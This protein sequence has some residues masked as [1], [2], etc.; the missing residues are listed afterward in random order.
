MTI[1]DLERLASGQGWPPPHAGALAEVLLEN[2]A[3][4]DARLRDT[5]SFTLMDRLIEDGLLTVRQRIDLLQTA[6]DDDHLF[7]GIGESITDGVFRRSFSV[8]MVPMVL[9]PDLSAG[10]LPEDL[11]VWTLDR[12]L[13]YARAERDWRGYVADK[14]WAH[15]VAHTADALDI[16]GRH[17]KTPLAQ[18]SEVLSAIHYLA[19]LAY[20]LGY[21]EDDRLAFAAYRIIQSGR[22]SPDAIQ[23]WLDCFQRLSGSDDQTETLGGANAEHFLRSLYFRFRAKDREHPWIDPIQTALDRFDIFLLYPQP[24]IEL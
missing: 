17:P 7:L 5:L 22:M 6:L 21:R 1:D 4:P 16:V 13:A 24:D 15:A 14:G 8:L 11:V 3:S 19:M 12:V 18:V 20:P 2:F 9:G 10:E 23:A